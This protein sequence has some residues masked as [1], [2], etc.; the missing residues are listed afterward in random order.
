MITKKVTGC[1][2]LLQVYFAK[3]TKP[4][5]ELS[6]LI[7]TLYNLQKRKGY[8]FYRYLQ[9]QSFARARIERTAKRALTCNVVKNSV[10]SCMTAGLY[11]GYRFGNR[12]T[13][14]GQNQTKTQ[15]G[16]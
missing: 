14:Y 15:K 5:T 1:Y 10:V 9:V 4:V 7:T 6:C 13:G 3:M 11:K 2:R 12:L 16:R 8:R